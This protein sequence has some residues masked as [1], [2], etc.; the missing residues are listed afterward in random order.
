VPEAYEITLAGGEADK[1]GGE[2]RTHVREAEFSDAH[3]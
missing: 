1:D 2:E 3:T